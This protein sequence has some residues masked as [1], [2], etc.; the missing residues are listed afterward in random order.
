MIFQPQV[1]MHNI[2]T[3]YGTYTFNHELFNNFGIYLESDRIGK[4]RFT[5]NRLLYDID[6]NDDNLVCILLLKYQTHDG[7]MRYFLYE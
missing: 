2:V 1:E 3:D 6:T 4:L 7:F 5:Q